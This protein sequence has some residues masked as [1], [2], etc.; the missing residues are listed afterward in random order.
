MLFN[1]RANFSSCLILVPVVTSKNFPSN[2]RR[3]GQTRLFFHF[4]SAERIALHFS[5]PLRLRPFPPPS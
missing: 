1:S 5:V 3:E 2:S 4:L